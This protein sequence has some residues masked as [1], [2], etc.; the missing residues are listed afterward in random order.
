MPLRGKHKLALQHFNS[1]KRVVAAS[2]GAVEVMQ[3][4]TVP[5]SVFNLAKNII[6]AGIL[7]LPA[8]MVSGKGT[9]LANAVVL[10]I[11]MALLSAWSFSIIGELVQDTG[12]K[13]FK[14][15]W[16]RT[17]GESSSG[18]VDHILMALTFG[19]AIMYSCF[20]G[21]LITSFLKR[22]DVPLLFKDRSVNIVWVTLSTLLPLCLQKDLSALQFSSIA[23]NVAVLY[24]VIFIVKRSLDGTYSTGG[25]YS[26][27]TPHGIGS[28]AIP[29][30]SLSI[31]T[32]VLLNMLATS[33]MAHPN[34]VMFYREL[35][36]RSMP[37]F[38][39]V[40]TVAFTISALAYVISMVAGYNTFGIK[41]QGIIL[42]NYHQYDEAAALGVAATALSIIGGYPLLFAGLRDAFVSFL[43]TSAK[44]GGVL[45]ALSKD[46]TL[47]TILPLIA[48]TLVALVASDIKLIVSLVGSLFGAAIVYVIPSY[49]FLKHVAKGARQPKSKVLF[50]HAV[51]LFGIVLGVGGTAVTFLEKFTTVLN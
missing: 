39:L 28:T 13:S 30:W 51:M 50:A 26:M 36:D 48:A 15:L 24:S 43:R 5:I 21:D 29:A 47:S 6:G 14:E 38:N 20:I 27:N 23:G 12:A 25:V 32:C 16:A 10:L 8:G 35:K 40:I 46:F 7:A 45:D 17:I 3:A 42:L 33:F 37:R 34:A 44:K 1:D 2:K 4:S 31:G 18:F 22:L 41:S 49:M 9:G 11:V 19:V